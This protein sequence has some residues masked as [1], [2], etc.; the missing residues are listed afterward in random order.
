MK[1]LVVLIT[2]NRLKYTK[3]TLEN[4]QKT[5]NVPHHLIVM[6]NNS[7]DGT[8]EWLEKSDLHHI[9]NPDNYYPGK[10][11]NIG[12]EEGLKVYPNATHLMRLDNDMHLQPGWDIK[13]EEFF[14]KIH[15]LGQLG[16]EHEA[17]EDP[18]NN[19]SLCIKVGGLTLDAW[20][21]VV[22]GP[23]IIRREVWDKGLRYDE[24]RW[25]APSGRP[26]MQEDSKFSFAIRQAGYL[27]G[28][29]GDKLAW[30]FANKRNWNEYPAYYRKTMQERGYYEQLKDH[31]IFKND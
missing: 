26:E 22:G 13:A 25:T 18:N 2:Y 8:R 14:E 15:E 16:I 1:L 4:F 3:R 17:V 5:I 20:P 31:E 19:G 9:L 27:I 24:S 21:G 29:M 6:D 11:C 12:W 7:D 30:T 23:N 28:H 10:A